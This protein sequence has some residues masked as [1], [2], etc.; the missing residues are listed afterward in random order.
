MDE[1]ICHTLAYKEMKR[2]GI[3]DYLYYL[4]LCWIKN[5]KQENKYIS[6]KE[7]AKLF[8]YKSIVQYFLDVKKSEEIEFNI[9]DYRK[10][11]IDIQGIYQLLQE[12][13]KDG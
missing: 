13:F 10:Y 9:L 1:N 11:L 6:D 12:V 7:I 3:T 2:L 4:R 5:A 8:N